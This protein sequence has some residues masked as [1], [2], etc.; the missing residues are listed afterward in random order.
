[1]WLHTNEFY[2]IVDKRSTLAVCN[3]SEDGLS[4]EVLKISTV[5]WG[6]QSVTNEFE[7]FITKVVGEEQM[8]KFKSEHCDMFED[9]MRNFLETFLHHVGL[10]QR[11]CLG[12]ACIRFPFE[13]LSF[14]LEE[15][16]EFS[17]D[18]KIQ[19]RR[20]KIK[21]KGEELVKFGDKV[22][23]KV[24]EHIKTIS[25]DMTDVESIVLV[26]RLSKSVVF[27]NAVRE[28]F[29]SNRVVALESFDVIKGAVYRGHLL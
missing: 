8:Q 24:T 27:Q 11:S 3:K 10:H 12:R 2:I 7:T 9:L 29:N 14:D 15:S 6:L 23:R 5:P 19:Q 13:Y 18:F 21:F 17:S 1:M 4:N 16:V 28:L 25:G 22:T 26:G 20:D